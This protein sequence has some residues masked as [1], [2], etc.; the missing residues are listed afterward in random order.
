MQLILDISKSKMYEFWYDY[1]IP[2]YTEKVKLCYTGTSSFIIHVK[3]E[4]IYKD[5]AENVESRFNTSN[6]EVNRPLPMGKNKVIR[7]MKDELGGRITRKSVGLCPKIYSCLK[8]SNDECKKAKGTKNCFLKRNL[9]FKDYKNCL[10]TSQII[11][12]F[13]Y[14][15]LTLMVLKKIKRIHEKEVIIQSQQRFKS[16][17]YNVFTEEINKIVL[18][19]NDNKKIQPIDF[20]ETYS[21]GMSK[22]LIWTREK[23]K[24]RNIIRKHKNV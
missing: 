15:E 5:I 7:M 21:H 1:L 3:A 20:I 4:D 8:D 18:S 24:K 16:K 2:K 23:L 17:R 13:N 12:I 11:N 14:V 6:Y 10:K 9:K 22:D 19:S